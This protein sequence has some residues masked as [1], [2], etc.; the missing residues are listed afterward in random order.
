MQIRAAAYCIARL[1]R[2]DLHR[3]AVCRRY[4]ETGFTVS[5]V[6]VS[7][8]VICVGDLFLQWA[9]RTMADVTPES[10]QV[11]QL[12]RPLPELLLLGCGSRLHRAP[13]DVRKY[14][15]SLGIKLEAVATRNAASTYNILTE[16]GR[17]VAAALL[18]A[19]ID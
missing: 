5:G 18:I 10:L 19:G 4:D 1:Y 11:F 2:R 15:Q 9:P 8:S 12:L 17:M 14:L 6:D 7:S 13:G 3:H 16:E